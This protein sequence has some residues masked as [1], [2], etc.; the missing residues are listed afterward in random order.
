MEQPIRQRH[1]CIR[2]TSSSRF[3]NSPWLFRSCCFT[4]FLKSSI[5]LELQ[6]LLL[7]KVRVAQHMHVPTM[8][9][10]NGPSSKLSRAATSS[11]KRSGKCRNSSSLPN[12]P[13]FSAANGVAHEES[14]RSGARRRQILHLASRHRLLRTDGT[15]HSCRTCTLIVGCV[16]KHW[17]LLWQFP[18][19]QLLL[20]LRCRCSRFHR[21]SCCWLRLHTSQTQQRRLWRQKPKQQRRPSY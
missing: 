21:L 13:T 4:L 20:K 15:A 1:E 5:D 8:T 19:T 17:Q 18:A 11:L 10:A 12:E 16:V 2:V 14:P 9:T 6:L 3:L 7:S